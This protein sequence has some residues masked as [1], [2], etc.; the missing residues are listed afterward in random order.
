MKL[1]YRISTRVSIALLILVAGW[2]S[3]FYF[4][5]IDE[6]NDETDDALE[7]YSEHIITRAL[8]G[9]SLPSKDNGTNN[10]YYLTEVSAEYAAMHEAVH[11]FEEMVYLEGKGET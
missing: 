11:Y 6:I 7:D 9:E 4:I 8:A 1:I 3:I 2:A 10:T 5:M